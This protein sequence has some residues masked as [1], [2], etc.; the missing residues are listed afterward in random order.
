LVTYNLNNPHF[1]Y[2]YYYDLPGSGSQKQLTFTLKNPEAIG[3]LSME[4]QQPLKAE[5]FTLEPTASTSRDDA[6][7]F[8]FWQFPDR[9]VEAGEAVTI[10]VR[11]TKSD[12]N[13]S[14]ARETATGA[15]ESTNVG[16]SAVSESV[17][18]E[19]P[20]WIGLTIIGVALVIGAGFLRNRI[21]AHQGTGTVAVTQTTAVPTEEKVFVAQPIV[22][23]RTAVGMETAVRAQFCTQCGN[24]IPAKAI[25]CPYCGEAVK[26]R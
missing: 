3:V 25:F 15:V 11:Y 8:T 5:N 21:R 10:Q 7:G 22:Q 19:P 4:V 1:F 17:I 16:N 14:V 23:P 12:P 2:E 13:P 6:S 24:S 20:S 26:K 18:T 9:A